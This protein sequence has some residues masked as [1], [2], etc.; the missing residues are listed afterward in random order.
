MPTGQP[1]RTPGLRASKFHLPAMQT[2]MAEG[3]QTGGGCRDGRLNDRRR[4]SFRKAAFRPSRQHVR[5][6]RSSAAC[7]AE[8]EVASRCCRA[9]GAREDE[10]T[11]EGDFH[12]LDLPRRDAPTPEDFLSPPP[13][14]PGGAHPAVSSWTACVDEA[15]ACRRRRRC[16]SPPGSPRSP[17]SGAT[18][19]DEGSTPRRY[20]E[21]LRRLWPSPISLPSSA[22]AEDTAAASSAVTSTVLRRG[23]AAQGDGGVSTSPRGGLLVLAMAA[24][25]GASRR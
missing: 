17:A 5:I 13:G 1:A 10:T 14:R 11:R 6:H 2:T 16:R 18:G 19:A 9:L 21:M 12:G 20:L 23:D 7:S 25:T 8:A 24:A 4:C 3:G 15:G 22:A